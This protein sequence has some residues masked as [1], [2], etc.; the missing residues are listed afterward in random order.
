MSVALETLKPCP[1]PLVTDAAGVTRVGGTRI[2]LETVIGAFN[3]GSA[4]EEILLKYPALTLTDIYAVVTYY[5][6]H[7]AEVDAYLRERRTTEELTR[8]EVEERLPPQGVRDRLLKRG[9]TP[10]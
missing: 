3:N 5:L 10:E 1:P 7:Q 6:W 2:R 9:E 4:P 8:H